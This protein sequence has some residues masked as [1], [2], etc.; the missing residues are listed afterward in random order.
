MYIFGFHSENIHVC[1]SGRLIR[2]MLSGDAYRLRA[3]IFR[4]SAAYIVSVTGY[5]ALSYPAVS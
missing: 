3:F 5:F 1:L 4:L 2:D